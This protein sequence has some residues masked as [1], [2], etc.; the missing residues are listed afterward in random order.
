[1]NLEMISKNLLHAIDE[2]KERFELIKQKP[3]KTEEL[4]YNKVK[5]TFET[6]SDLTAKWKPLADDWI[7]KTNPKYIH[8]TQIESTVENI[9]Q[10]ILQSFYKDINNQRF[11]NLYNSVEYILKTMLT[12][13]HN[14]I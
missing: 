1:M 10:I 12:E 2:C 8:L 13:L 11:Y 6:V 4:F 9:E 14:D 3:E 5:P 7:V